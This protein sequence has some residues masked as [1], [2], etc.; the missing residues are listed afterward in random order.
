MSRESDR[1]VEILL[2]EDNPGDVRLTREILRDA[3]VRNT[4][5]HVADGVEALAFLARDGQY[6]DAPL[7]DLILLDLN[8][9]RKDGREVPIEI[10][11]SPVTTEQGQFVLASIIDISA[12]KA[13]DFCA[14]VR[15]RK[16]SV[17]PSRPAAA[18]SISRDRASSW[19]C[20]CS[21][22]PI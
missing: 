19:P 4:L 11:L 20:W 22:S 14:G 12:R 10:G 16:Y 6:A 3:K 15:H 7:P 17:G 9:P 21:D 5:H 2:V 1:P 18:R 13:A 8:L